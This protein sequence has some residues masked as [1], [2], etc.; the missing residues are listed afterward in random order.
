MPATPITS[1]ETVLVEAITAALADYA[2][3]I[4]YQQ[5]ESQ[6]WPEVVFQFQSDIARL[7][8]I[9]DTGAETVVTLKA[10]ADSSDGARSALVAAIPG[11]GAI[12]SDDYTIT[13]RYMRGVPLP[14]NDGIWQ[15]ACMFRIRMERT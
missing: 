6:V 11:M 8:W 4:S 7:D 3:R 15:S 14:P 2:P 9:D 13:A 12:E 5:A 10:M 1:A